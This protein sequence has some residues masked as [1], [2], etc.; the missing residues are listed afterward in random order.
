[1]ESQLFLQIAAESAKTRNTGARKMEGL[2][3]LAPRAGLEMA[4]TDL[5]PSPYQD[6]CLH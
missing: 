6:P 1:M 3:T 4:I 5:Q 2:P